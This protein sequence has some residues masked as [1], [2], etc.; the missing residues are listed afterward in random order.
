MKKILRGITIAVLS[1]MFCAGGITYADTPLM[2]V[3][4]TGDNSVL[5][6]LMDLPSSDGRVL[7]TFYNGV[8][9]EIWDQK[10]EW[11]YVVM[12][13]SV[14]GYIKTENLAIE[15]DRF[16]V[17]VAI[18]IKAI[19]VKPDS[20]YTEVYSADGKIAAYFLKGTLVEVHGY[21]DDKVF[22]RIGYIFGFANNDVLCATPY[23]IGNL[24]S[25]PSLGHVLLDEEP[26]SIATYAYPSTKEAEGRYRPVSAR[27]TGAGSN[28]S[29][30]KLELLADLGEY[31]Q[32]RC[33]QY[34]DFIRTEDVLM[35]EMNPSE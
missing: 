23:A 14:R 29:E 4:N 17:P 5:G 15:N 24:Y 35:I 6:E 9:V 26:E 20:D 22:V 32:T 27:I 13:E 1:F 30:M 33:N 12:P 10:G 19:E 28:S 16:D 2:A 8:S 31:L 7:G 3:V 21:Y 18:P 25:L 34:I 11:S